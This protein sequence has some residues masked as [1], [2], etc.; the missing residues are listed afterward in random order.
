MSSFF[1]GLDTSCY[2]TSMAVLDRAGNLVADRRQMLQVKK[3]QKGLRQSEALFQHIRNMPLLFEG[4]GAEG[5]CRETA[6]VAAGTRPR[7]EAGS[8]MP[9]F[10]AG[11]SMA[12]SLAAG[13]SALYIESSH[14]EGHIMA[15]LWSAA[16]D[17]QDFWVF[18]ISGGTTEILQAAREDRG[19]TVKKAGGSQDLSAGQ[20]IDRI[21][22]K[23]GLPFPAGRHL[24]ELARKASGSLP[25]PVAVH[26]RE[27]S[28]SGPETRAARYL[29]EGAAPEVLARSVE[30]C[31]ARSLSLAARQALPGPGE[32]VLFV[33]GVM[34]NERIKG[35]L[36]EELGD[37]EV[38][39][40]SP[41]MSG[42][43]AVGLAEIAR[44]AWL[45]TNGYRRK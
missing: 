1:L 3:G 11:E 34:A 13:I 9:V 15:G 20:F 16:L 5:F 29:E 25:L 30:E 4:A 23:M 14:Q 45:K 41:A 8:Y 27:I 38:H 39:Y 35:W 7:P 32:R 22:V 18:H 44:R 17:W 36:T 37:M 12:R 43:N 19:F 24:E 21:G 10:L 33:G 40:A 6:A 28:F 2:T 31:I 26:R 42:D